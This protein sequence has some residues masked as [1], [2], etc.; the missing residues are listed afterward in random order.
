[1]LNVGRQE[2][3]WAGS[4]G[5]PSPNAA[6]SDVAVFYSSLTPSQ[7]QNLYVAGVGVW[8]ESVPDEFG[9]LNLNWLTGGQLQESSNVA[10]PYTTIDEAVA[11]YN[12]P[13]GTDTKFY[14]I[15]R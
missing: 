3:P 14:R 15:K 2:Y 4:S 6:F 12:V 11:P 13:I 1:V 7:V 9:N 5:Q 10:G 8:I